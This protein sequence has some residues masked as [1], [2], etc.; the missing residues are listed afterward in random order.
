LHGRCHHPTTTGSGVFENAKG[1]INFTD[2]V[3]DGT[4]DYSEPISL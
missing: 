2:N 4:A 3:D 1:L